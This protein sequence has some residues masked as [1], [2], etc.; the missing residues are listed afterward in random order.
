[1]RRFPT[2]QSLAGLVGVAFLVIGVLG[3][4]PGVVQHYGELRW[5]KTGSGAELFGVFQTSILGNLIH[6]GFGVV[7]LAGGRAFAT[8]RLYL[9]GGGSAYFVLGI[10]GLLIDE[11]GDWNVFPFD[12][13]DDW[14]HLGVGVAMIYAGLAVALPRLRPA[15]ST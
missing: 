3:F 2:A 12:R 1:M 5:W 9:T 8:A 7:G 14:L 13:A 15:A 6:L 4:V 10:Y 11:L